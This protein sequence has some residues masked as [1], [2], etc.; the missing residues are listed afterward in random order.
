MIN[1]GDILNKRDRGIL[2]GL[3]LGDGNLYL[4]QNNFKTEYCKLTIGHSPKQIEYLNHKIDLIHST[5]GGKRP[6]IYQYTS[7]NKKMNKE[8]HNIQTV[9]TNKYFKQMHALLYP[10]G[11]KVFTRQVLDYLTD[12]GLTL[13]FCD[14]G[15]GTLCKSKTGKICGCMIRIATY[16]SFEEAEI[17]K[18]WFKDVYNLDAKFDLDKRSNKIS[19]RFNTKDSQKFISVVEKY[20]PKCMEYK[21]NITQ[22]RLAP[23]KDEDIV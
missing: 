1:E 9:K 20:I 12:Q 8:Y 22:E 5:L 16:F 14:D 21:I 17:V 6:K 11:K 19:I 18:S 10:K 15:S 3:V 7:L 13:W 23:N 2:Y 4:A